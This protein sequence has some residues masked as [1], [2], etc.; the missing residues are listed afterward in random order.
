MSKRSNILIVGGGGYG[1]AL[2]RDL[3]AKLG[4]SKYNLVLVSSRPY[5]LNYAAAVRF[6]IT[7]ADSLEDTALMPVREPLPQHSMAHSS[8]SLSPLS[9]TAGSRRAE[10][11]CCRM[12]TLDKVSYDV[13]I[14]ASGHI[15]LS[16]QIHP[17]ISERR[18]PESN[19]CC[20]PVGHCSCLGR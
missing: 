15:Y 14:F 12:A 19:I 10:N 1:A 11:C 4:P 5:Y 2:A 16:P 18:G 20:G 3:S 17:R 9:P 7:A 6:T 13:L 8:L